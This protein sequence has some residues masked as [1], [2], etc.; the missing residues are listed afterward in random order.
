M[1]RAKAGIA[2]IVIV[3]AA[4]IFSIFMQDKIRAKFRALTGTEGEVSSPLE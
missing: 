2:M 1:Q 4:I 3:V